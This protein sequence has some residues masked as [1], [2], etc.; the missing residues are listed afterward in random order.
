MRNDRGFTLVEVLASVVILALL[1]TVFFQMFVFSQKTTTTSKEKLVALNVAQGVLER[2][3]YGGY[4]EI[5]NKHA[6]TYSINECGEDAATCEKLYRIK[7]NNVIYQIEI[8]IEEEAEAGL[9]IYWATVKVY[10]DDWNPDSE[11]D[12]RPQSSVEGFVEL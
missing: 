12:E 9:G 6:G 5:N 2:I 7:V 4:P 1:A 8:T 11:D 3:K 10:S